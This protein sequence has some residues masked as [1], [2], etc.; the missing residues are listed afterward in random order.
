MSSNRGLVSVLVGQCGN[1]VGQAVLH[2]ANE[3]HSYMFETADRGGRLPRAVYADMEE[4]VVNRIGASMQE[5]VVSNH[6]GSGN[7]WGVGYHK[8]GPQLGSEVID[9]IRKQ[10]EK[11]DVCDGIMFYGSTSGGTGSGF[12][13]Y[14][15]E[16]SLLEIDQKILHLPVYIV[17]SPGHSDVVTSAYNTLFTLNTLHESGDFVLP[18]DN[19]ALGKVAQQIGID[20]VSEELPYE[21]LNTVCA[22]FVTTL[23]ACT[24]SSHAVTELPC[25]LRHIRD[26]LCPDNKRKF[27]VPSLG[28]VEEKK[29]LTNV[30]RQ[31]DEIFTNIERGSRGSLISLD[32]ETS[33]TVPFAR[34]VKQRD[35]LY[36]IG[37]AARINHKTISTHDVVRNFGK[38]KTRLGLSLNSP[39]LLTVARS[40]KAGKD[41]VAGLSN[42]STISNLF[43]RVLRQSSRLLQKR[44][45]LH[46]YQ[47]FMTESDFLHSIDK[48]SIIRNNYASR[49]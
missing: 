49:Y 34:K 21:S 23:T 46:H 40:T 17:S 19:Q 44:S 5:F 8:F 4:R 45:F 13:S 47:D 26:F 9:R 35:I 7:N 2:A 29:S 25:R 42:R 38:M 18:F 14:L 15:M 10:I 16:K 1:Q 43:D 31:F 28:I 20:R 36:S 22:Q 37:I 33:P 32:S 48:L 27:I 24:S 3:D 41:V 6:P 11:C 39:D 30:G 12:G